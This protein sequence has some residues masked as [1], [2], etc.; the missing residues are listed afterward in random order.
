MMDSEKNGRGGPAAE[1]VSEAVQPDAVIAGRRT[2]MN[3]DEIASY[4]LPGGRVEKAFGEGY[5]FRKEQQSVTREVVSAF[6]GDSISLVEAPTGTGK[7]LSYLIPSA[8]WSLLNGE[9]VVVSTNTINLQDQII[10]K[11]MPM[12]REIL[13]EDIKYALVKGMRNYLCLLRTE[14]VKKERRQLFPAKN[15]AKKADPRLDEEE[16]VIEWARRTPD[17]ST[18]D[19]GFAPSEEVWDKFAAESESCIRRDCPH[20]KECFFFKARKKIAESNL[21]VVNHHLLFSDLAIKRSADKEDAG[22]LPA[23]RRVVIDE[24][25]NVVD[26]A[27]SHFSLRTSTVAV[28]KTL[29]RLKRA[30]SY[31]GKIAD[32]MKRGGARGDSPVLKVLSGMKAVFTARIER[33]EDVSG[34]FFETLRENAFGTAE[35]TGGSGEVFNIRVTES[36]IWDGGRWSSAASV[37][38]EIRESVLGLSAVVKEAVSFLGESGGDDAIAGIVAELKAVLNGLERFGEVADCFAD[39]DVFA[40]FVKSVEVR[41]RRKNAFTAVSISPIDISPQLKDNLYSKYG[42]V[43]LTSATLA[44]EGSF[45]FQQSS[46]GLSDNERLGKLAVPSPFRHR[47]QALLIIPSDLPDPGAGEVHFEKL[48]KAVL[49]CVR[50][51]NGGALVLFTSYEMLKKVSASLSAKLARLGIKALIQG[52]SPR[53]KLLADFRADKNAALFATDSFRE[54]VDIAGDALRLVVITRLPFRVPNEPVFQA[55]MEAIEANGR[56]AFGSYAVPMAVVS[57]RQAFGRLIRTAT[58]RGAVAVLDSRIVR[59]RYGKRFIESIPRCPT[60]S[61]GL[62]EA[63]RQAGDFFRKHNR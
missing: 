62:D 54:G 31:S 63:L 20:Y 61:G 58:D 39:P 44:V 2:F 8:R 56:D 43:I 34:Y 57:F 59:R 32:S 47:K 46:L 51:S 42:T 49:G 4:F 45:D 36:D 53:E 33:V 27:T 15:G 10:N 29:N 19:L 60:A 30:V 48:S 5:E 24:A 50:V 37:C 52:D 22:I 6:N 3:P 21:I 41:R 40:G 35:K 16:A 55:R 26:S 9:R 11:D 18:S 1:T 7:T 28:L 38:P 14:T 17:G 12:L 13:G 23:T 25:H